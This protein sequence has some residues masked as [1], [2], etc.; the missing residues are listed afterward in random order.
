MRDKI[1]QRIKKLKAH[2]QSA[3][4]IG[5][6]EEAEAFTAKVTELL[7]EYNI[8]MAE[9][10]A[11]EEMGKDEFHN[12][13]YAESVSYKGKGIASLSLLGLVR[14]LCRYNFCD[15][16][17]NTHFKTF[18]IYGHADNVDTVIWLYH[19]LTIGFYRL[20]SLDYKNQTASGRFQYM[21][22][23]FVGAADGIVGVLEA[24]RKKNNKV[25]A[26]VVLNKKALASYFDK[27]ITNCRTVRGK[28][29]KV[30]SSEAYD[31]GYQTG[32]TYSIG[33]KLKTE[34]K[35]PKKNLDNK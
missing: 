32:S 7:M 9:V 23:W 20:A 21:S 13:V 11:A 35:N 16:T 33:G 26:L 6:L 25:N 27:N 19:Y 8:E 28:D 14:V 18:R 5:S 12:W 29:K 17:Y 22:D 2:A 34:E 4:A 31:K 15:F 24:L 3:I 30:R 10:D 1:I